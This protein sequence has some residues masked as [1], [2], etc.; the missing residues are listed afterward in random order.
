L[1]ERLSTRLL[2]LPG[3]LKEALRGMVVWEEARKLEV[4]LDEARRISVVLGV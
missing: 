4:L 2:A 3:G 1:E